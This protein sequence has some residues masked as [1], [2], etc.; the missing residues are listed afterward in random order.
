M[1]ELAVRFCLDSWQGMGVDS[2][3][4]SLRYAIKHFAENRAIGSRAFLPSGKRGDYQWKTYAAIDERVR[5]MA[6]GL[7][8]LNAQ[9][10]C[11]I[12]LGK[13]LFC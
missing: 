10:V 1:G 3:C 12:V 5:N 9:V 4:L 2:L 6:G 13:L 8:G 11:F 7:V